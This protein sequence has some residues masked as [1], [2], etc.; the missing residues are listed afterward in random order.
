MPKPRPTATAS[1][2]PEISAEAG[3]RSLTRDQVVETYRDRVPAHWGLAV[4]GV[5]TTL[6]PKAAGIALTF[7]CCGGPGG[8]SLDHDLVNVLRTNQIPA[9]FFLNA[10]W[11]RANPGLAS[12][13]AA[14]PLFEVA[15]HGTRHLPL[16]VSGNSAYG[17]PGTANPG[18]AYDEVMT[19]QD[20]LGEVTGTQPRFFRSG[21]AH[22]D[23]VAAEIVRDLGLI[24]VNFSVNGDAGASFPAGTVS[25]QFRSAT[26]GD[27]VIAHANRPDS[28][29]AGGVAH[30]IP[31]LLAQG[32]TFLRLSDMPPV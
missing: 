15:N 18:E 7:D 17:I 10:R 11:V 12:G 25:A 20:V 27:I 14:D 22:F 13:L 24:P 32:A 26:A 9:T 21:T 23:E 16:S 31:A 29:T 1:P 6:P 3:S 28:G 5:A 30:A 8:E 2:E 19:N 4:P